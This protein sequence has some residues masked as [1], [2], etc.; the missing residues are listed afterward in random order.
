[1]RFSPPLIT[2]CGGAGGSSTLGVADMLSS[3]MI[4]LVAQSVTGVT[5]RSLLIVILTLGAIF[6]IGRS[7]PARPNRP[8]NMRP[9]MVRVVTRSAPLYKG[10]DQQRRLIVSGSLGAGALVV[11]AV[12]A[13]VVSV[14]VAYLVTTV[15]GLLR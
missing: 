13:V 8:T 7:K 12:V 11:G 5:I 4:P 1:M 10:P 15:T 9:A 6:L 2:V 14:V 3:L